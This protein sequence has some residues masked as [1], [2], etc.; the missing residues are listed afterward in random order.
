MDTPFVEIPLVLADFTPTGGGFHAISHA[1]LSVPSL[2]DDLWL[3][4]VCV[5][6]RNCFMS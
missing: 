4:C 1:D 6:A 2:G 3:V 5:R